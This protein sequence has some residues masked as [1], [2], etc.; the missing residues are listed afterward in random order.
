MSELPQGPLVA[1]YGDDYTGSAAV[2]DVLSAAGLPTVLFLDIPKPA[3]LARFSGYRGIG[4]AGIA[5]SRDPEWMD[6][7]LPPMFEALAATGA[8]IAHYKTCSTFDSAPEIGSIGR[9]IDIGAA[10]FGVDWTPM[11]VAAPALGRW[12]V[13]GNLFAVSNGAPHRL[14]RHPSMQHH[15]VT[16]MDEADL[17]RHLARQTARRIGLVDFL[18]LQSGAGDAAL[19]AALAGGAQIVSLDAVDEATL[20]EAGRLIWQNRDAVKFAVGSQ[21][22]EYAL[23]AHWRATGLLP[24]DPQPLLMEAVSRIVVVSGSCSPVTAQQIAHAGEHGFR[25]IPIDATQAVDTLAW[26]R[27]TTRAT[28]AALQALS[29]GFDPLVHTA[30]GPDDPAVAALREAVRTSGVSAG[31]VNDRIGTGLGIVLG[32]VLRQAGLVRGAIAGGDTSGH[33][34]QAMGIRALTALASLAP[35]TGL[36]RAF[37]E[38]PDAPELELALKGGQIGAADFFSALRRGNS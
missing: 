32:D 17:G 10:M 23:V 19:A 16:P 29:E 4:I 11:V 33:A 34:V 12:Q 1:F 13:F 24:A 2:M 38:D 6:R 8:P 21:G 31:D 36:C 28:A 22:I 15:P 9:A 25:C 18:A 3:E 5:R 7:H 30:L 27:E 20:A 35:G 14:D 26:R 37:T